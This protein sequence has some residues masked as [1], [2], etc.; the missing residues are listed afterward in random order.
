MKLNLDVRQ[1]FV[2]DMK[3]SFP[4]LEDPYFDYYVELYD[5]HHKTKEKLALLI[6]EI[7]KFN[8]QGEFLEAYYEVRNNILTALKN[9]AYNE[10]IEMDMSKFA[11]EKHSYPKTDV[12]NKINVGKRFVSIDLVK[13]NFQALKYVNPELVLG[14]NTYEELISQFTNMEY[15]KSSKYIRQVIL[16]NLNP[17]RT[18]TVEKYLIEQVLNFLLYRGDLESNQIYMISADE[19]VYSINEDE[20]IEAISNLMAVIKE[21]LNID[22]DIEVYELKQIGNIKS[23]FIKEFLNKDGFEIMCVPQDF[24]PQ[25]LKYLKR[26]EVNDFDKT[27]RNEGM[28]AVY[29]DNLNLVE[30]SCGDKVCIIDLIGLENTNLKIGDVGTYISKCTGQNKKDVHLIVFNKE[31]RTEGSLEARSQVIIEENNF[32]LFDKNIY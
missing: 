18:I 14:T 9:E 24:R 28:I 29:K 21:S 30:Y 13:A 15:M 19:I 17:K 8:S 4:V 2:S 31:I 25:V 5:E 20:N 11:I 7:E 23:Y 12:F 6:S 16:G 27:F 3:I 10:F 32:K 1:R 26:E 22:V